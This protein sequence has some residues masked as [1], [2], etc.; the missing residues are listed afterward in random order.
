MPQIVM[1]FNPDA[2]Q[3]FDDFADTIIWRKQLATENALLHVQSVWRQSV[4]GE[5]R[6]RTRRFLPPRLF[7][8]C[9]CTCTIGNGINH[10]DSMKANDCK[11]QKLLLKT[12]RS[13]FP[14]LFAS[15]F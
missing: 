14:K 1:C 2:F 8:I 12:F 9:C 10:G 11:K 6:V 3:F 5:A 7:Q 4:N 13:L 15:E